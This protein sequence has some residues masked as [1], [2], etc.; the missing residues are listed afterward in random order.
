MSG[1]TN[2]S[3]YIERWRQAR[4]DG[5]DLS[6]QQL[7]ADQPHLL[8]QLEAELE[9]LRQSPSRS[10]DTIPK[11][12]TI[13][14]EQPVGVSPHP[15]SDDSLKGRMIGEYRLIEELGRGGMGVVYRAW[16][17]RMARVVALK[18]ILPNAS[19]DPNARKRFLR[20]AR[21]QGQIEHD[22]VTP[23]Y[24]SGEDHGT[25]YI[26]MPL[27]VGEPLKD[28]L[29]GQ[30][31]LPLGHALLYAWQIAN[32][33]AAAHAKKV[34]HRDIKPGNV[35]VEMTADGEFRRIRILDFGLARPSA[36]IDPAHHHQSGVARHARLHESRTS[37]QRRTRPSQRYFQL[38]RAALR[39]DHRGAAV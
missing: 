18:V 22:N 11:D 9:R 39:N 13:V 16:D 34:L 20:E 5:H 14:P 10:G 31:R 29:E 25:L 36:A 26:A 15:N 19:G 12:G 30:G 2:L 21:A 37:R 28:I 35:W 38:R 4:S 17:D 27:L 32:G 24:H 23:I 1:S 7:C 3:S 8:P 6:A 33:L